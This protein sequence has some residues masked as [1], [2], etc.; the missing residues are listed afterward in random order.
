MNRII[1]AAI[2]FVWA[3]AVSSAAVR[4]FP[5]VRNQPK[6]VSGMKH[7]RVNYH[8]SSPLSSAGRLRFPVSEETSYRFKP[9]NRKSER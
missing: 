8:G 3:A 2:L 5:W 7:R 4:P 1:P 6:V 9:K